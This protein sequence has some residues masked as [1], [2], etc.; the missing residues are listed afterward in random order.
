MMKVAVRATENSRYASC[1]CVGGGGGVVGWVGGGV[2][3][4][5]G[6]VGVCRGVCGGCVVCVC[7]CVMIKSLIYQF[8]FITNT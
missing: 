6:C 5:G 1:V 8:G 4:G 3:V 7:V 2:C